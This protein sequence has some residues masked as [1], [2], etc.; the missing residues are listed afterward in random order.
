MKHEKKGGEG[1]GVRGTVGGR[2]HPYRGVCG[3]PEGGAASY[4]CRRG[5]Q[6]AVHVHPELFMA[7]FPVAAG[8]ASGG[9]E[10]LAL[11]LH[12]P[13][14]PRAVAGAAWDSG[15]SVKGE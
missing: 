13:N 10:P 7:V 2:G 1:F 5:E 6:A 4:D 15:E 3:D 11:L 8:D 9:K 14:L 12:P